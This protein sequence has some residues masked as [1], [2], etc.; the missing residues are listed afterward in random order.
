MVRLGG[1]WVLGPS[2]VC[3]GHMAEG[4]NF[5]GA[6]NNSTLILQFRAH[7]LPGR[8]IAV[9]QSISGEALQLL[10]LLIKPS[11]IAMISPNDL[12]MRFMAFCF[13]GRG[14]IKVFS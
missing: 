4:A 3:K 5:H 12:M 8:A 10:I 11:L 13:P 1:Q 6:K 2:A 9:F 7:E 14:S